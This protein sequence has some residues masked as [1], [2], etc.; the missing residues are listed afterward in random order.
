MRNKCIFNQGD[1]GAETENE[2]EMKASYVCQAAETPLLRKFGSA[3][4][5]MGTWQKVQKREC[6]SENEIFT[7]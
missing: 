3:G 7:Y 6:H 1:T 5:K 4:T 2:R